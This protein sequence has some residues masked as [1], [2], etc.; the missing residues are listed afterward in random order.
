VRRLS[1][2]NLIKYRTQFVIVHFNFGVHVHVLDVI[3]TC[4]YIKE[5]LTTFNDWLI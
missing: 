2:K 5:V 4:V 3:Q 1:I